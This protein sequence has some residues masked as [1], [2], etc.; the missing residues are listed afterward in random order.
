MALIKW[1][2]LVMK[3]YRLGYELYSESHGVSGRQYRY[4]LQN[5]K[6]NRILS[7]EFRTMKQ[8]ERML[9]DMAN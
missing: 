8:V 3:A 6:T 1:H 7:N 4:R 2:K 9:N 5:I